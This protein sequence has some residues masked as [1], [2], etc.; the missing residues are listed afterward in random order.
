MSF[1]VRWSAAGRADLLRLH[2]F[3]LDRALTADDLSAADLAVVAIEHAVNH[4]LARTPFIFR[5][6]GASLTTRELIIPFGAT[7]YVAR[8]EILPETVLVLGVRHQREEDY[9]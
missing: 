5:R 9:R 6:V 2:D 7:G 8:F 1:D 4:Q 3:L